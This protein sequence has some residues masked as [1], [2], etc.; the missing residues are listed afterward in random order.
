VLGN[1]K[2]K[3]PHTLRVVDATS[4]VQTIVARNV[5]RSIARIPGTSDISFTV[6]DADD[7]Y[8][9]FIL[10]DATHAGVPLIDAVEGGQDAA[11]LGDTM[12]HSSGT[13][14]YQAQPLRSMTSWRPVRDFSSAG[15]T[16]ITRIAIA[17]TDTRPALHTR[18]CCWSAAASRSG[19]R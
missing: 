10:K 6:Q 11:W 13:T 19:C 18:N 4:Q 5:G 17:S 9:F 12:L 14:I 15:I 8:R 2:K 1:E 7:H 3:E 16:S